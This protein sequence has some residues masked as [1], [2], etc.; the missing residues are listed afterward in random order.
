[1]ESVNCVMVGR[2]DYLIS[3]LI[4]SM[5]R[6]Y[7]YIYIFV[8]TRPYVWPQ[9]SIGFLQKIRIANICIIILINAKM[10]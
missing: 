1:M 2:F 10:D 9:S 4:F 5:F 6:F 8:V 7:I 3:R